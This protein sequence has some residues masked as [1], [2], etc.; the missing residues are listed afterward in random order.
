MANVITSILETIKHISD[1]EN[2]LRFNAKRNP[3]GP[4]S[5]GNTD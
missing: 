3:I 1:Y 5:I 2:G 4:G